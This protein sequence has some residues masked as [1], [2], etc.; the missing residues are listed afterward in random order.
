MQTQVKLLGV[1]VGTVLM[2]GLAVVPALDVDSTFAQQIKKPETKAEKEKKKKDEFDKKQKEKLE[3][4]KKSNAAAHV[5]VGMTGA[6]DT[7]EQ[8]V[9]VT[10]TLGAN[11]S[12]SQIVN[13]TEVLGQSE[14]EDTADVSFKWTAKKDNIP[15]EEGMS[16]SGCVTGATMADQCETSALKGIKG[17]PTR[18]SVD[19]SSAE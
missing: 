4:A 15:I 14:G 19:I 5:I 1:L 7:D 10:A 3:K 8:I 16:V 11:Y 12:K 13:V 2:L 9:K 17:K 6:N 18:V